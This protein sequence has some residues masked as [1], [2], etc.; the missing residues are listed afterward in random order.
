MTFDPVNRAAS[1]HQPALPAFLDSVELR[2]IQLPDGRLDVLLRKLE[3]EVVVQV[4]DRQG[5]IRVTTTY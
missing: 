4:L 3:T 2:G 1:F 5:D